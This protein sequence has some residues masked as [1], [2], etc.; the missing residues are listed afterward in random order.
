MGVALPAIAV[1]NITDKALRIERLQPSV[2]MGAI[3]FH[4]SHTTLIQ[5]MT[6]WPYADHDDGPDALEMLWSNAIHYGAHALM[7]V[8]NIRMAPRHSGIDRFRGYSL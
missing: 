4:A 5:Q 7:S 1:N 8:D 2:A 3:K 6:Q